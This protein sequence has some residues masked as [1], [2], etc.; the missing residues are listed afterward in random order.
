MTRR[1][2]GERLRALILATPLIT[3]PGCSKSSYDLDSGC[4]EGFIQLVD[5]GRVPDGGL[6]CSPMTSVTP[7]PCVAAC[8]ELGYYDV[9][10]C[11]F[12]SGV[13]GGMSIYCDNCPI[14]IGGRRPESLLASRVGRAGSMWR[15]QFGRR[16]RTL[17]L[18]APLIGAPGCFQGLPPCYP[19]P[20]SGVFALVDAGAAAF[21]DC[22]G[23]CE[24][25]VDSALDHGAGY[26][27]G[28]SDCSIVMLPDAGLGLSCSW[29][30]LCP[31]GRRPASLLESPSIEQGLVVGDYFA[32]A[33]R[34]EAASIPAFQVLAAELRAHRAPAALVKAARRSAQD[35]V[36]HTH[37]TSALARRYGAEP[38]R[39]S[40]GA[41]P[42]ER[43]LEAIAIE[44]AV[45]GCVRETYG[46][47]VALWQARTAQDPVVAAAMA[48][49]AADE[50]RHAELAWEV[51]AWAEPRLSPA[52]RHRIDAARVTALRELAIEASRPLHPALVSLAG[53]PAPETA[54]SLLAGLSGETE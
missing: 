12:E 5:G 18:A 26:P 51:A 38:I 1:K 35:E 30:T 43:P 28:I 24:S 47:L 52:A 22:T 17:A 14:L 42:S 32:Q 31:G 15:R 6:D 10:D 4:F 11:S 36:R 21:Q 41:T 48:P 40:F 16:L 44:N 33:S 53:L 46:A 9:V 23:A 50:T 49:I 39:P 7:C 54:G 45:E 34:L 2:L 3:A 13:D 8:A 25:I 19:P 27:Y 37:A 29:F 20:D